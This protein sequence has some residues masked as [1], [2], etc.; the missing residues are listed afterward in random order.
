MTSSGETG[1]NIVTQ[2]QKRTGPGVRMS[3][4]PL[5]ASHTRWKCPKETCKNLVIM[6]KS[7]TRFISVKGSLLSVMHDQLRVSLYTVILLNGMLQLGEGVH[8]VRSN[9]NRG[10]NFSR[11]TISNVY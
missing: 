7:L 9:P 1:F 6:L 5:F 10:Y 2:L 4:R 11:E 8:S 3:K